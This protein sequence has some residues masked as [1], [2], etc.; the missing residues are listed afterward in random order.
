MH[1]FLFL[2]QT[3]TELSWI[4][5]DSDLQMARKRKEFLAKVA[6]IRGAHF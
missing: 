6:E 1:I 3:N 5:V 2:L 4:E